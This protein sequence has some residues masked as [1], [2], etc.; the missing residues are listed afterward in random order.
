VLHYETVLVLIPTGVRTSS[1]P[2]CFEAG[3]LAFGAEPIAFVLETCCAVGECI[4]DFDFVVP[5]D[6]SFSSVLCHNLSGTL[7]SHC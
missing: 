6:K 2:F 5:A 4:R 1:S 3:L 7:T